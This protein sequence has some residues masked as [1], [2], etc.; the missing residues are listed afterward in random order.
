MA[1][2]IG[3]F[4]VLCMAVAFVSCSSENDYVLDNQEMRYAE[5]AFVINESFDEISDKLEHNDTVSVTM[6]P[7]YIGGTMPNTKAGDIIPYQGTITKMNNIQTVWDYGVGENKVPEVFC[8][9][10]TISE[11]WKISLTVDLVDDSYAVRGFEG[12][13]TGWNGRNMGNPQTREQLTKSIDSNTME[14]FTFVWRVVSDLSGSNYGYTRCYLPFDDQN[15][16]RIYVK[17]YE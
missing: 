3:L 15:K 10:M 12:E 17:I 6:T 14:F 8:G 2:I 5:Y 1:K 7:E 11:W 4:F 9:R 13:W 16:A